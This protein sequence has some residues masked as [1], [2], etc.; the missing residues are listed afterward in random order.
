M[1]T[2]LWYTN[3]GIH[4]TRLCVRARHS[5]APLRGKPNDQHL[6]FLPLP[7]V[8]SPRLDSR[9]I[10]E[11]QSV[12]GSQYFPSRNDRPYSRIESEGLCLERE[13]RVSFN[14]FILLV[15]YYLYRQSG[16]KIDFSRFKTRRR[17]AISK[18]SIR[19]PR[20]LINLLEGI[21]RAC[22]PR[23]RRLSRRD[24]RVRRILPKNV[25]WMANDIYIMR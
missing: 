10:I 23:M 7:P 25:K 12:H 13:A 21:N 2:H 8:A 5:L 1:I 6:V 19:N 17:T 11:D 4:T 16:L 22:S 20:P 18:S 3:G 9:S 14:A 24:N 15:P